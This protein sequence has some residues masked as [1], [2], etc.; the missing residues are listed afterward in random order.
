METVL[1]YG[2]KPCHKLGGLLRVLRN[3]LGRLHNP[4]DVL[5]NVQGV[6]RNVQGVLRNVLGVL[7]KVHGMLR[8]VLDVVCTSYHGVEMEYRVNGLHRRGRRNFC[9]QKS[10][11]PLAGLVYLVLSLVQV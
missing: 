8:N 5:R 4:L 3:G 1:V 11:M 10:R 6:L 2:R 9:L 7:R